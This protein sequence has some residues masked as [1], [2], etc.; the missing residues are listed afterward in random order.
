M[1]GTHKLLD[2]FD[3]GCLGFHACVYKETSCA[4]CLT[5]NRKTPTKKGFCK[6]CESKRI[7]PIRKYL[8]NQGTDVN[9]TLL[10]YYK[11]PKTLTIKVRIIHP[12][13]DTLEL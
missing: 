1:K 12:N 5:V 13:S 3:M 8:L 7:S 6:I 9:P 11:N 10:Y 4:P 2:E